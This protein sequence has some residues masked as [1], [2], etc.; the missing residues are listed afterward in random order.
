MTSDQWQQ[1]TKAVGRRPD[2]WVAQERFEICPVQTPRGAIY[3][4]IG[5]YTVNGRPAGIYG[6]FSSSPLIDFAAVDAAVLIVDDE[7]GP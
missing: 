5:V 6:R 3:P 4:C 1:T 2:D 7:G